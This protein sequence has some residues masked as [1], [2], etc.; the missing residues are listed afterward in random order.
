MTDVVKYFD[1]AV[2][3]YFVEQSTRGTPEVVTGADVIAATNLTQSSPVTGTSYDF[4]GDEANRD[5]FYAVE[6]IIAEV[7]ATTFLPVIGAAVTSSSAL[8]IEDMFQAC[9]GTVT[10]PATETASI[11]FG[12][13]TIGQ[14]VTVAGLT[15]TSTGSTTAANV[16]AAFASLTAG[17]TTGGGT[18]NG[19]YSGTLGTWNSSTASSTTVTFTSTSTGQDVTDIVTAK[20]SG[21]TLTVVTSQPA[22]VISNATLNQAL[23]TAVFGMDSPQA[24]TT[25]VYEASDVIGMFDLMIEVAKIPEINWSFKGNFVAPSEES[26]LTDDFGTQKNSVYI[27]PVP[28]ANNITTSELI[29]ESA[30]ALATPTLGTKNVCFDKVS[31]SNCF[32]ID[33]TR[34]LSGC[35]DGFTKKAIKTD[36]VITIK[37]DMADATYV[38]EAH[39]GK[40]HR[41][42]LAYGTVLGRKFMLYFDKLQ[43]TSVARSP[44][45][46]QYKDLT[47]ENRSFV[48]LSWM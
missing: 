33:L 5:G 35:E 45:G 40:Y 36:V 26:T 24:A 19:T 14:Y 7:T 1:K 39:Y 18:S 31:A 4:L 22:Y 2:K 30:G 6:D 3:L 43:L 29:V 38:P 20:T 16:A 44:K 47:F 28:K 25:K 8:A 13:L 48:K 11:T 10:A 41:F 15:F 34:Y 23:G 46:I 17:A 27:S 9:G 12:S 32:G 37:E 42:T 21:V